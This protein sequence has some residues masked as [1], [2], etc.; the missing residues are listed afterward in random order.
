MQEERLH[1]KAVG[2]LAFSHLVNDFL[3]GVLGAILPLLAM[4]FHLTYGQVGTLTMASNASSSLVQ[5]VFGYVSD[6]R[7]TPWL[8]PA[9]AILLVAGL[10][11]LS[12]AHSFVW[13]LPAVVVSGIGSAVFHPDAS[14][15]VFFASGGKRGLA[16]SIFQIGGNSGMA[17][18]ALALWF[19]GH[20]GLGGIWWFA[21]PALASSLA[22]AAIVRWFADRLRQHRQRVRAGGGEPATLVGGLALLVFVVTVRAFLISGVTTYVP[23][24]V[25]RRDGILPQDVWVYTFT[26]LLFGALGTMAGGPMADRWGQRAV[27]RLSMW[28]STPLAALV[29]F[30][31]HGWLIADLAALGFFLLSTFAVTVVYG[32]ELAPRHIAM[33]SG[34]LIGFAGGIGGIGTMVMGHVADHIGLAHT[35]A[36]MTWFTLLAALC[37][38]WLPSKQRIAQSR[39]SVPA[40]RAVKP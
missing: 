27:V 19:L 38:L 16:Q 31:A 11:G 1:T 7:G 6:R 12:Y 17:L 40:V 39:L 4:Q 26:F 2:F 5:P 22:L 23:L 13:L 3:N 21:L 18:S 28:V 20:T 30:L 35:L 32:Q 24:L 34:L 9:S 25:E 29:P 36:G 8:L 33:V 10:I 37:T 14:R 15:A